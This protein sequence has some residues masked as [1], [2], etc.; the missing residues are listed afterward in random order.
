MAKPGMEARE[1]RRKNG[2]DRRSGDCGD[3][4]PDDQGVPLP[5]PEQAGRGPWMDASRMKESVALDREASGVEQ[6]VAE[7]DE[8]DE[9]EQLQRVNEVVGD[10]RGDQVEPEE[11]WNGKRSERRGPE[12]RVDADDHAGSERPGELS[13]G[14][15]DAQ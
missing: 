7:L 14:A 8:E 3:Q 15:A 6:S 12:Q 5:V 10:L 13:R 11:E 4:S 9:E 1:D 2:G